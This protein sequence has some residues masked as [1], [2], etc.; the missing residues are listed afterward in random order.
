MLLAIKD[1]RL[2]HVVVLL[3][4]FLVDAGLLRALAA[5]RFHAAVFDDL[6]DRLLRALCGHAPAP[7]GY[8]EAKCE[9]ASIPTLAIKDV[10]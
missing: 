1:R 2:E 8:V 5:N 7:S 10:H 6:V 9:H 3:Q 4:G